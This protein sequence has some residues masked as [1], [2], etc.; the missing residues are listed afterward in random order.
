MIDRADN[1]FG[2]WQGITSNLSTALYWQS[3]VAAEKFSSLGVP[4]VC[5]GNPILAGKLSVF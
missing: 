4:P 2:E 5:E 3:L 1:S